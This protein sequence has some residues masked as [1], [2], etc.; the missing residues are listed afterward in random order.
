MQCCTRWALA[1]LSHDGYV[2]G[3][4]VQSGAGMFVCLYI[5]AGPVVRCSKLPM[6]DS[7]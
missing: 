2:D 7:L 6:R 4:G 5:A 1:G 3:S